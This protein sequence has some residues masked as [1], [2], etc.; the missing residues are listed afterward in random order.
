ML[1]PKIFYTPQQV[2]RGEQLAA[3]AQGLEM[4]RL[5]ER[6]GQAVFTVALAQYPG[7]HHWLICCGSGNNG[8]MV[9]LLPV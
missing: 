7:S 2:K 4:F 1:L 5:M 3:K 9:I 6:A 8:G